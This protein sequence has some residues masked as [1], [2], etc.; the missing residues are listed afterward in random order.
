MQHHFTIG[1]QEQHQV[2]INYD[3][4][5]GKFEIRVDTWIAVNDWILF[6]FELTRTWNLWVGVHEKHHLCIQKT[7][8]IL[9]PAFK[10]HSYRIWIDNVLVH[11]FD[12]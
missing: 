11:Q 4:L 2:S 9:L 1:A 10:P 3:P 7:R 5:W 12:A 8:P 6:G